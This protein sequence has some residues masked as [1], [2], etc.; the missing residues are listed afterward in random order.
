MHYPTCP[1]RA[2]SF[3]WLHAENDQ[4]FCQ[5]EVA[6]CNEFNFGAGLSKGRLFCKKT[7]RCSTGPS[8]CSQCVPK[9]SHLRQLQGNTILC[10]NCTRYIVITLLQIYDFFFTGIAGL[11]INIL[12]T[13][14][15]ESFYLSVTPS[16]A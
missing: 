13:V 1:I 11:L 3:K 2:I 16:P 15:I 6:R 10:R 5:V 14:F 8:L 4:L 12:V 9:S 7:L